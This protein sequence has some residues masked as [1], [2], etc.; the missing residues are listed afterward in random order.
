[1]GMQFTVKVTGQVEF[2]DLYAGDISIDADDVINAEVGY[3]NE[4]TFEDASVTSG[5]VTIE[6]GVTR[7]DY[8]VAASELADFDG[9]AAF[10]DL[11]YNASVSGVEFTIEDWPSG[12]SEVVEVI[13]RE[14]AIEVYAALATAGYAVS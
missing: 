10:E 14:A 1:M 4:F 7:E 11:G 13:G 12:F 9:E 3:R 2:T 5:T 8:I 6:A